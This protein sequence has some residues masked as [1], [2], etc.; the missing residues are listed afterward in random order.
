MIL[1]LDASALVKRYVSESG[2]AEVIHRIGEAAAVGTATI[3]RVEI[4]AALAKA[5]RLGFLS[6]ESARSAHEAFRKDWLDY[7]RLPVNEPV[8]DHAIDLAWSQGLRGYDAV[9]LATAVYWQGALETPVS[10]ATFDRDLWTASGRVGLAVFP[11][12][13]P[14]VLNSWR[15][16]RP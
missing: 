2:S 15:Q 6:R 9:Q 7:I 1:Y 16:P 11:E 14:A 4:A 13:L 10:F 5:A 3:C 8:L 12:D